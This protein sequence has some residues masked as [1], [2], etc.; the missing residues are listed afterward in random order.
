MAFHSMELCM[1]HTD[2]DVGSRLDIG[3][4]NGI[5]GCSIIT[6]LV[7]LNS[8]NGFITHR[9]LDVGSSLER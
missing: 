1:T 3:A 6:A 7:T 5:C 2:I 8:K 4:W 9:D